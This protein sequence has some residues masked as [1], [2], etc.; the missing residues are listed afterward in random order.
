MRWYR[1]SRKVYRYTGVLYRY[2]YKMNIE[3]INR[4]LGVTVCVSVD[5]PDYCWIRNFQHQSRIRFRNWL[6]KPFCEKNCIKIFVINRCIYI[7]YS[8]YQHICLG[9]QMFRRMMN[10]PAG[11]FC[12][13]RSGTGSGSGP[14]SLVKPE[15][16]L[17]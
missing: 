9:F 17:T 10:K 5:D 2:P 6:W 4:D 12:P 3:L 7:K 14:S 11:K 1:T 8:C 16:G 13:V 15:S